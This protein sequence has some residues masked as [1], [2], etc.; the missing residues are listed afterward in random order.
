MI[1]FFSAHASMMI[2]M[3]C[4]LAGAPGTAAAKE[5]NRITGES[6]V[7]VKEEPASLIFKNIRPDTVTVRN[8]YLPGKENTVTY[9]EGVDYLLDPEAGTLCRI[10]GSSIPDFSKNMLYGQANFSHADFPGFGNTDF[11]VYVDY[12]SEDSSSLFMP[13]EQGDL[14][15]R[16]KEKL[17]QG[18][19]LKLIAF[20]DSITAGGDAS[21]VKLQ[22]PERYAAYLREKYPNADIRLENGA[23]GGDSTADGLVRLEE[24]VLSRTPDLVLVAFGMNDHNK[25]GIN[26]ENFH[27]NLSNI[28]SSIRE[29]TGADIILLS[30][31][32]PNPLWRHGSHCMEQYAQITKQVAREQNCAYADVYSVWMKVLARKDF[33][34]LLGNNVNH[35]S[36]F[37][38]WL[39]CEVLKS[40]SF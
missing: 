27:A 32:P 13:T 10:A 17:T 4:I 20:G 8:T 29:K 3:L 22:F 12:E 14:L 5:C 40:V 18:Q 36:D 6:L 19:P 31:F 37:G 9:K 35:P 33:S 25:R 23:T 21:E 24:K 1:K 26:P 30:T 2:A 7:L 39:Y 38:H 16:T 15:P 34:S 28:V 11:F